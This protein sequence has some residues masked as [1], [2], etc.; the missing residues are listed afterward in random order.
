MKTRLIDL[1]IKISS[2]AAEAQI[3]RKKEKSLTHHAYV[4]TYKAIASHKQIVTGA[5][6]E[7]PPELQAELERRFN[8]KLEEM[9]KAQEFHNIEPTMYRI[10]KKVIRKWLKAGLSKEEI[11][12]LP[13]VQ[14]A[15]QYSAKVQDLHH[16]RT[17]IVRK[18]SRHSQLAYAFLRG[19]EYHET[20][21]TAFN[22]P[23]WEKVQEI[24]QRFSGED[25]RITAQRFEQWRQGAHNLI[26]GRIALKANRQRKAKLA[27]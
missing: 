1:Q 19:K 13:G 7:P 18:E 3:I 25:K 8:P 26:W 27:A 17:Q 20:E 4:G 12:A 22:L 21:D 15:L 6:V 2:L 9:V 23:N 11:L 24:A 16:H 14:K 10:A 5:K